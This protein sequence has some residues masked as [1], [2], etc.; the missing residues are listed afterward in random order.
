MVARE[1]RE[2]LR[3]L[4]LAEGIVERVVD[5]RGLNA[6]TRRLVAVDDERELAAARLLVGGHV[7]QLRELLELGEQPRRPG[8][9]LLQVRVLQRVLV[10]G[11][12]QASADVQV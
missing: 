9:E 3:D 4:A 2:V 12:R 10:L 11:A 6:E 5:E 7:A 8:V 1:L